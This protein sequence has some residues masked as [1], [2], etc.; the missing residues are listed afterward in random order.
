MRGEVR[1]ESGERMGRGMYGGAGNGNARKNSQKRNRFG[2]RGRPLGGYRPVSNIFKKLF[3]GTT[4]S[5][6]IVC[7]YFEPF[8]S[9]RTSSVTIGLLQKSPQKFNVPVFGI[10][11]SK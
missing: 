9:N 11:V 5:L 7:L 10:I 8:K 2:I 6:Q 1:G 3:L 4:F